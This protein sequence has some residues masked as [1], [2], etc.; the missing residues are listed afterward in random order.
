MEEVISSILCT[1]AYSA[2]VRP[3]ENTPSWVP[4]PIRHCASDGFLARHGM[5]QFAHISQNEEDCT[6]WV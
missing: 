3:T 4:S 2:F 6:H 5:A 1:L